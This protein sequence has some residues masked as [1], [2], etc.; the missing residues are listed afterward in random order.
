MYMNHNSA[1]VRANNYITNK[2]GFI[3]ESKFRNYS[4]NFKPQL[5]GIKPRKEMESKVGDYGKQTL[6]SSVKTRA[7]IKHAYGLPTEPNRK[8]I[9]VS[10]N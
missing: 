6:A 4:L 2:V 1:R 8:F 5:G 7:I 10:K 3:T 9:P